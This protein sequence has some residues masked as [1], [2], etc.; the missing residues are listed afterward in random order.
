MAAFGIEKVIIHLFED[1]NC[2]VEHPCECPAGQGEKTVE[3]FPSRFKSNAGF[4]VCSRIPRRLLF[5]KN[6]SG[7]EDVSFFPIFTQP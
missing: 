2:P 6:K 7:Y 5:F 3:R 1:A 4:N